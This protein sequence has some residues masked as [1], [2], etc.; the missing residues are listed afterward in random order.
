MGEADTLK[1][2]RPIVL[3]VACWLTGGPAPA[4]APK[5]PPQ[6]AKAG[7]LCVDCHKEETPTTPLKSDESCMV[8]HGDRPAMA[9]YTQALKVNPHAPPKAGHPAPALCTDCHRQHQAPVVKC[10]ECHPDFKLTPR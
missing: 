4:A 3:L 2:I 6:H 9:A 1:I 5:L 8:C 10:L 7:L